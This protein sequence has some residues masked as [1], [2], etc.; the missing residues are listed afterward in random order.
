MPI[1]IGCQG[2]QHNIHSAQE[3]E[4]LRVELAGTRRAME[5]ASR[6]QQQALAAAEQGG[7]QQLQR[8][9]AQVRYLRRRPGSQVVEV[10]L[11]QPARHAAN[12]PAAM[13][14]HSRWDAAI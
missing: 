11:S 9:Q 6:Q 13:G 12:M 7:A 5:A 14:I 4:T 10:G 1:A 2:L 8:V 3:L